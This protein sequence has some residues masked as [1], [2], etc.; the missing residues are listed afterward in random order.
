[1][2]AE[3]DALKKRFSGEITTRDDASYDDARRVW[4]GMIDK[5][6]AAVARPANVEDV[7]AAVVFARDNDMLLAVRCGAH[8]GPG[9]S[10]CDGGLVI[11]LRSMNEVRVDPDKRIATVAGGAM[12]GDLDKASQE[13]RLA[14]TAGVVSHT[15]VA[16]LTLGGGIGRTHRKYGL[17]IDNLNAVEIVTA[18]GEHVRA[19]EDENQE[20][21]WGL[22]GAG[23]NFGVATSF[24]FRLHPLG[25]NVLAGMA[26]YPIESA[27]EA[28]AAWRDWVP[29]LDDD[30]ISAAQIM[31]VPAGMPF[32]PDVHGMKAVVMVGMHIDGDA[33]PALLEPL[34]S[35]GNPAFKLL[36][37]MPYLFLQSSGDEAYA[38]GR[39]NYVKGGLAHELSDALIKT[40]L[41]A[42]ATS[43]SPRAEIDF[44]LM[45]GYTSR[46]P[47]DATAFSGRSA[48]AIT[49]V[50]NQWTDPADDVQQ[51]SWT[52]QSFEEVS[53]HLGNANYVN[54][55]ENPG[56]DLRPVYGDAKYERLVDLKTKYDPT[57]LFRLNQNIPPRS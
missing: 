37:P 42:V 38:W 15:G 35:F 45:G 21:F 53:Q 34:A 22:R 4:N 46:V 13:H 24:E 32:S 17:S 3:L 44:L 51:I 36:A 48:F 33:S 30:V 49:N 19:S 26:V 31:T 40:A 43:T 25:P 20:L 55:I 50:E 11:D 56:E 10:T 12:L 39:R 9:F 14:T 29:T 57:N 47:E 52:K 1:M 18:S 2:S 28:I 6:P 7:S 8:S 5:R 23:H 16:G 41:E 27:F 54:L